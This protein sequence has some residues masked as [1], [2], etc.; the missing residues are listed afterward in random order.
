MKSQLN[1]KNCVTEVM[2]PFDLL[3]GTRSERL[4]LNS[5]SQPSFDWLT[6]IDLSSY[7]KLAEGLFACVA[8]EQEMCGLVRPQSPL[9]DEMDKA[10]RSVKAHPRS[11]MKKQTVHTSTTQSSAYALLTAQPCTNTVVFTMGSMIPGRPVVIV[12]DNAGAMAMN[13]TAAKARS[14]IAVAVELFSSSSI[15]SGSVAVALAAT[16]LL[17]TAGFFAVKAKVFSSTPPWTAPALALCIRNASAS[18]MGSV[19]AAPERR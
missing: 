3:H 4:Y 17:L 5:H 15:L 6:V 19:F 7:I 2:V 13:A 18:V 11:C 10:N 8:H 9:V 14:P 16:W 1:V 12:L